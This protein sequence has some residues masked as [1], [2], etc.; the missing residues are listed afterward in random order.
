MLE[1]AEEDAGDAIVKAHR[2]AMFRHT[3][4][5]EARASC[6]DVAHLEQQILEKQKQVLDI[7]Q[8]RQK[9]LDIF[10]KSAPALPS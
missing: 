4:E 7:A 9:T 1:C 3:D 5:V 6:Q 10:F 8:G 2:M